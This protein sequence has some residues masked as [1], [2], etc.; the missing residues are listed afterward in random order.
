MK[1]RQAAS[2]RIWDERRAGAVRR[3]AA[4]S[5]SAVR[6]LLATFFVL[7]TIRRRPSVSRRRNP[8]LRPARPRFEDQAST[9]F[10]PEAR[11]ETTTS[12]PWWP[13]KCWRRRR[14]HA[15]SQDGS[16]AHLDAAA[17][18]QRR[19][20]HPAEPDRIVAAVRKRTRPLKDFKLTSG[21]IS[22]PAE[23]FRSAGLRKSGVARGL[24]VYEGLR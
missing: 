8:G 19:A 14:H 1:H 18:V 24:M 17:A 13:R 9:L 4:R 21:A 15:T 6:G 3:T 16:L 12:S 2:F 22:A 5:S 20:H 23:K 7:S 10:A 11:R